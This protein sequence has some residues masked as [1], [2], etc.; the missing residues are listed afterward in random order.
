MLKGFEHVQ[1]VGVSKPR[2]PPRTL[3]TRTEPR[4]EIPQFLIP[5]E[6]RQ[7]P[8]RAGAKR[9]PEGADGFVH[10][11]HSPARRGEAAGK[12][13]PSPARANFFDTYRKLH[14]YKNN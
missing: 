4:K 11:P 14:V 2:Q 3:L 9:L 7:T 10:T 6:T 8:P 13:S 5:Q 12:R 1:H